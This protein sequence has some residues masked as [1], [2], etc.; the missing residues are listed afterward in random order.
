ML[1]Y[2]YFLCIDTYWYVCHIYVIY[3]QRS[4]WEELDTHLLE[5][6]H[7]PKLLLYLSLKLLQVQD[8][9][10]FRDGVTLILIV[11][12]LQQLPESTT[13]YKWSNVEFISYQLYNYRKTQY[14]MSCNQ[15]AVPC[16]P[17]YD[18]HQQSICGLKFHWYY[19]IT[20][21]VCIK[22]GS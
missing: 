6:L 2:T 17:Y 10:Y 1:M 13:K 22:S 5:P 7:D 16:L 8:L 21:I 19:S 11:H 20:A 15:P 12:P 14:S 9:G 3:L 4:V 18:S